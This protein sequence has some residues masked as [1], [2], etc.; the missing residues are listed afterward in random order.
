VAKRFGLKVEEFGIG[1]PPRIF[2]KKIGDTLYS[3]N[4]LPFGAF[5]KISEEKLKQ[6][7]IW[8]RA[9]IL[10]AGIFSFWI[11]AIVLITVM[12]SIGAPLSVSDKE[13]EDL[14]DPRV[15]IVV[16]AK[17]SPAEKAKLKVGDIIIEIK[18]PDSKRKI[19]TKVKEVQEFVKQYLGKEIVLTIKR[20]EETLEIKLVPRIS[21]PVGE[22]PLGIGLTRIAIRKYS[23]IEAFFQGILTT[24]KLTI[25]ILQ[26]FAKI[27]KRAILGKPL[28]NKI[29]GPIGV[30]QILVG[31]GA[32][33]A[34]VFLQTIVMVALNVAIINALPIPALDGGRLLFLGLEKIRKKPLNEKIEQ[35]LNFI[36]LALLLSL[37]LW[38]TIK[39]IGRLL[40]R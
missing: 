21:P 38:V 6:K 10:L 12:F 9:L 5:V 4:L 19:I 22:G 15:Q 29:V 1:F 23:L 26:A 17:N 30:F 20:G 24:F 34:V 28:E 2:G 27:L 32:L 33:G 18:A 14:I 37:I 3:L 8:Q 7:P 40:S 39:D 16:I 35:K 31:A 36:F 11:V 25:N 13:N